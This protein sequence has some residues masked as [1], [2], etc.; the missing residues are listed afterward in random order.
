MQNLEIRQHALIGEL[1]SLPLDVKEWHTT[2]ARDGCPLLGGGEQLLPCTPSG[3]GFVSL[4]FTPSPTGY[5]SHTMSL[6]SH[7]INSNC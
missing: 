3:R 4:G 6:L 2:Q 1:F 7:P 5:Q